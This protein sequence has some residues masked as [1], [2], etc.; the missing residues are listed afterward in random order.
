MVLALGLLLAIVIGALLGMLVNYDQGYVLL[1][2]GDWAVETSVWV[3]A[4]FL[5]LTYVSIRV[6]SFFF[7]SLARGQFE[8]VRWRSTRK[9]RQARNKTVRGLLLMTEGRWSEA[10]REFLAGVEHVETPL[11]NYLHAARAAHEQ[12]DKEQRDQLLRSA[13]Q[14]NPEAKFAAMLLQAEFQLDDGANEQALASLLTLRKRVAKHGSVLAMLAKCYEALEDWQAL[15]EVLPDLADQKGVDEDEI[16]RLS[17]LIWRAKVDGATEVGALWKSMPKSVRSDRE[18]LLLWSD[19]LAAANQHSA[20]Q[21]VLELGLE[22]DWHEDLVAAYGRLPADVSNQLVKAQSWLKSRPSDVAL[23]VALGRLSLRNE[24][25][26]Q[27]REYFEAALKL[28][29]QSEVYAELGRLCIALGDERRGA[30]YLLKSVRDLPDLPL[31]E[32]PVIRN[33]LA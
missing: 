7:R 33:S 21:E 29:P 3:A 19:S 30:D 4:I 31:P 1:H 13:H 12:G 14:T 23:N 5:V 28:L 26:E 9:V 6:L 8:L 2:F 15:H 25:F 10:K 32:A 16:R 22:Q 24:Q 27:G 18:L 17:R 11:I 20:A